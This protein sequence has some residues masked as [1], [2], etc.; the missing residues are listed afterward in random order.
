MALIGGRLAIADD[1]SVGELVSAVGLAQ[2]LQ[3][4]LT[5]FSTVNAV[6]ASAQAAA[7]RVAEVLTAPPAAVPGKQRLPVAVR[8]ELRLHQVWTGSLA[9]SA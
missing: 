2:F 8:G 6:V 5:T 3:A 1:I 4:P 9:H 7:A